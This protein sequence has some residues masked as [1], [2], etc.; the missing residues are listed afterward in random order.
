MVNVENDELCIL[1]DIFFI[2][3]SCDEIAILALDSK[4]TEDDKSVIVDVIEL[5]WFAVPLNDDETTVEFTSEYCKVVEKTTDVA[6]TLGSKF[7]D[8]DK[9]DVSDDVE[10]E[11][12]D[13]ATDFGDIPGKVDGD[14]IFVSEEGG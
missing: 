11:L 10:V 2:F 3:T 5:D 8:D 12:P 4:I 7:T 1:V 6:A 9:G 14:I 13:D